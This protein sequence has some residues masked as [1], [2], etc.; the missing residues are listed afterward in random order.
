MKF[1]LTIARKL[2]GLSIVAVACLAASGFA[3]LVARHYLTVGADRV[4][5]AQE[6]LRAQAAA[7][8]A[9]D[10]LRGDVLSAML[11]AKEIDPNEVKAVRKSVQADAAELTQSM[12]KLET[13]DIGPAARAAVAKVRP[14]LEAYVAQANALAGLAYTD[15]LAAQGQLPA[16]GAS[17]EQLA[18]EMAAL[19]DLIAANAREAEAQS[20]AT[21][22]LTGLV[23]GIG[24]VLAA[25]VL[26]LV[27][28]TISR[29]I[30]RRIGEA[31]R[32][33]QT[34]AQGDLTSHI[35]VEGNDE[36]A[37]LLAALA[38]MNDNLV[39][40]VGTV[41]QSSEGIASGSVQIANGNQDLSQRTEEQASNLQQTAASM[42]QISAT[43][44]ANADTTR[45]ASDMAAATSQAARVSGAAVADLVATMEDITAASRR[46]SEIT[47]VIDGIAFQTNILA[48][49]A[50]VE[51]ARAGDQG[52][53]FAVVAAEVR[54]LA[55]RSA[56]AA[57]EIKGLIGAS[58][59]KVGAGERQAAHAGSSMGAVVRQ[60]EEMTA[61]LAE[62]SSATQEQN[63]GV[64]EVSHAVTQMD[65]VTQS[66]ASLVE[67]AAAAAE[68]LSRQAEML[69]RAVSAFRVEANLPFA[70]APQSLTY[71]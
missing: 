26:L 49:N 9:H 21:S 39:R 4:L 10:A 48:L 22:E 8:Q 15:R 38:R 44:R 17:F 33:A 47:G 6:A 29:S 70:P 1:Q 71:S 66:N 7:D 28:W 68:S 43:V 69:V 64:A 52:R 27:S 13:L 65:H 14:T 32:V 63:K 41:R 3:G 12:R 57:K 16:F 40:L 25:L 46:I 19:G 67:E 56:A 36:T 60:A 62:I 31:V 50:A 45:T 2:I 30:V 55:Q 51:A 53:G 11:S 23:V 37:Q 34:V 5:L 61:L 18:Q 35:V 58:V 20:R 54:T 42:E 59:E 24:T